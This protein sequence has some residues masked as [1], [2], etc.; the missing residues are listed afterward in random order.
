M[1]GT[2]GYEWLGEVATR[3]RNGTQSFGNLQNHYD[4]PGE[5]L[6]S[7]AEANQIL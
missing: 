3:N 6:T 4:G 2:Y 5:H 7:V 1:I